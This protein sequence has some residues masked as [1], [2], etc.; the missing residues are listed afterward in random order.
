M[1]NEHY[2]CAKSVLICSFRYH[3]L[4]LDNECVHYV[5]FIST[6]I[7]AP[8]PPQSMLTYYP[9]RRVTAKQALTHSYFQ[10]V[11]MVPPPGL[12]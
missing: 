9:R 2:I 8:P 3:Y 6:E 12:H 7:S 11:Y 4:V 5:N 1:E 10:D